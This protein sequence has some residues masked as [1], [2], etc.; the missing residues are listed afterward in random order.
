MKFTWHLTLKSGKIVQ[1]DLTEKE[2]QLL[3]KGIVDFSDVLKR[4]EENEL[5]EDIS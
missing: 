1:Y 3:L 2:E 4:I 5:E